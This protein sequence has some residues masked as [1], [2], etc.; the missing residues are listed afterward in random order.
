MV[1]GYGKGTN[2][3]QGCTIAKERGV[4]SG[5]ISDG[6]DLIGRPCD[7]VIGMDGLKNRSMAGLTMGQR[8]LR[9]ALLAGLGMGGAGPVL[10]QDDTCDQITEAVWFC[11]PAGWWEPM[12]AS[13]S[14]AAATYIN[15]F[16]VVAQVIVEGGGEAAGQT[17]ETVQQAFLD[18][19]R[20][21]FP[22]VD[23]PVIEEAETEV[24]DV[25][26]STVVLALKDD[27]QSAMVT[28]TFVVLPNASYRFWTVATAETYSE[29]IRQMHVNF[30]YQTRLSDPNG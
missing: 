21:T 5:A 4:A 22:G 24:D 16:Q 2:I 1:G 28:A 13:Q 30:L 7:Q 29:S 12:E 15:M 25:P 19:V 3:L 26:G 27:T 11:D 18:E 6:M 9:A 20:N 10:A 23:I 14:D 17:V 8:M